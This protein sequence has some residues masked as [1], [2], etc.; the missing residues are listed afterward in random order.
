M[1]SVPHKGY[2]VVGLVGFLVDGFEVVGPEVVVGEVV[3][4]EVVGGEVVGDELVG[5]ELVVVEV[6]L[7][8]VLIQSWPRPSGCGF[9]S[10][11]ES[12]IPYKILEFCESAMISF[13]SSLVG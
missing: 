4:G 7:S 9:L 11:F 6:I 3:G 13:T 8:G 5:D 1:K 12:A 2:L 10:S